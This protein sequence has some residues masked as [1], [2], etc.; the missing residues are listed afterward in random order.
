MMDFSITGAASI[1]CPGETYSVAS[2]GAVTLP[3]DKDSCIYTNLAKEKLTDLNAEYDSS[4]DTITVTLKAEKIIKITVV[5][6]KQ[7]ALDLA[8]TAGATTTVYTLEQVASTGDCDQVDIPSQDVAAAQKVDKNLKAGTCASAGYSVA[9][10][11]TTKKVPVLGTLTI[12]KFKKAL[13]AATPITMTVMRGLRME[14]SSH[15]E[16]PKPKGCQSGEVNI[17]IQGVKGDFCSPACSGSTCPA[18]V[19]T[20]VT[21]KPTCALQDSASKKKYCALICTP[22]TLA[23]DAQC[24]K[25]GSCKSIQSVGVCTYDD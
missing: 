3:T 7:S 24:G 6:K 19:P 13:L 20:G 1:S 2:S 25:N 23:G 17:K 15:Y 12:S 21:A 8:L 9:D 22:G 18:D 5:L 4:A 16:D 11:T 10:G 14:D